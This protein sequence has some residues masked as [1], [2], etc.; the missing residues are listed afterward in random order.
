MPGEEVDVVAALPERRDADDVD[1]EAVEEILPEG[2]L[3]DRGIEVAVGGRD[4]PRPH[5]DQLLAADAD[6]LAAL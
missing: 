4:H 5:G 3:P 1:V 2:A 6:H